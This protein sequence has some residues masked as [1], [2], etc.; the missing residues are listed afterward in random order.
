MISAG[1]RTKRKSAGQ[2]AVHAHAV[3][4][5]VQSPT[6]FPAPKLSLTRPEL[7]RGLFALAP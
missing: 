3:R 2:A 6:A 1:S 4:A 5:V 7:G